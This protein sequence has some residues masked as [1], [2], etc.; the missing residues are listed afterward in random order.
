MQTENHI[1]RM[2][3]LSDGT[4]QQLLRI[5]NRSIFGW[6]RRRRWRPHSITYLAL[7][8]FDLSGRRFSYTTRSLSDSGDRSE[9]GGRARPVFRSFEENSRSYLTKR[10]GKMDRSPPA[11]YDC[12]DAG[13]RATQEQLPRS[14]LSPTGS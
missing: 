9:Q 4:T 7:Y 12:M 11:Q 1:R 3:I 8:R 10:I 14:V 2:K 5:T 13:G 6:I